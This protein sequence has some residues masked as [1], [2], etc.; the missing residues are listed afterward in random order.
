MFVA[1]G[2]GCT[3]SPRKARKERYRSPTKPPVL[4]AQLPSQ[5]RSR[6]CADRIRVRALLAARKEIVR[7]PSK[8]NT[9]TKAAANPCRICT[10]K[11]IGL[12]VPWNQHLQKNGGRGVLLLPNRYLRRGQSPG[13]ARRE[14]ASYRGWK[15]RP[16]PLL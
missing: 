10:Y 14:N 15:G 5:L 1:T 2:A 9:Y 4:A 7:N 11:I 6:H 8:M 12:K 3:C 13:A 16:D